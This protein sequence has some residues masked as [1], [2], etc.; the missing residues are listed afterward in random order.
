M[1]KIIVATLLTT[2]LL[3]AADRTTA[4]TK[5]GCISFN[6]LLNAMP[7][8]KKADTLLAKFRDTLQQEFDAYKAEY[9][10]QEN[11]LNSPDT[12]K[13]N[14]AQLPCLA[15]AGQPPLTAGWAWPIVA[16]ASSTAWPHRVD[17]SI[18]PRKWSV[19]SL[20]PCSSASRT[21]TSFLEGMTQTCC[22]SYPSQE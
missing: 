14:I 1:R 18:C 6:E 13:Y 10:E 11:L 19:S 12:I 20:S 7:E 9:S 3:S 22:P 4:Q 17:A 2:V 21:T 15:T 5:T 8:F 16:W